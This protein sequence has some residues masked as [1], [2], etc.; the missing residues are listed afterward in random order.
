MSIDT[1]SDRVATLFKNVYQHVVDETDVVV[2]ADPVFPPVGLATQ[3]QLRWWNRPAVVVGAAALA[4]MVTVGLVAVLPIGGGNNVVAVADAPRY[5]IIDDIETILGPGAELTRSSVSFFGGGGQPTYM[6]AWAQ[7][8]DTGFDTA[9]VLL[10]APTDS[11]LVNGYL[12]PEGDTTEILGTSGTTF[13]TVPATLSSRT[14]VGWSNGTEEFLLIGVGVDTSDLLVEADKLAS[15]TPIPQDWNDNLTRVYDG[16]PV[17]HPPNGIEFREATYQSSD[18]QQQI[19]VF[20]FDEWPHA[21]MAVL[22]GIP[23]ARL[24][25]IEGGDAFSSS[26]VT[27]GELSSFLLWTGPDG[28]VVSMTGRGLSEDEL[29]A[30]AESL[31]DRRA[32]YM[33]VESDFDLGFDRVGEASVLTAG[34]DWAFVAQAVTNGTRSGTCSWVEVDGGARPESTQCEFPDGSNTTQFR[35]VAQVAD[36]TL[37]VGNA[38]N[39]DAVELTLDDGT[40]VQLETISNP[41]YDE[42]TYFAYVVPWGSQADT[43]QLRDASGA[44]VFTAPV[45]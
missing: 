35:N 41:D 16:P 34:D 20:S 19:D 12:T 21:E 44:V 10:T 29:V 30:A 7:E 17:L 27:A 32:D 11:D 45:E 9:V 36:G 28:V 42:P 1:T 23:G 8:S 25:S 5:P 33:N 38:S 4:V 22:L 6:V 43:V 26:V 14:G 37:L 39:I 13:T 24:V 31:L 2:D 3:K 15:G 40:T 18:G